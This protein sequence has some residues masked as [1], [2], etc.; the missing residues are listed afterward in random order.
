MRGLGTFILGFFLA[1]PL[2]GQTPTQVKTFFGAGRARYDIPLSPTLPGQAIVMYFYFATNEWQTGPICVGNP[3]CDWR[4]FD[5]QGNQFAQ[6]N[7]DDEKLLYIPSTKGGAETITLVSLAP[8]N[9]SF[10]AMIFPDTLIVQ[11]VSPA[12][13]NQPLL[14]F[15]YVSSGSTVATDDS[16]VISSY[17]LL[18]SVPHELFIGIGQCGTQCH[19]GLANLV[20]T[21]AAGWSAPVWG[22]EIFMSHATVPAKD[23][24]Q[25]FT[26]F[27]SPPLGESNYAYLGIQGFKAIPIQ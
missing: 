7:R 17:P 2:V 22:G 9:L 18:S 3:F 1:V 25:T 19:A 20:F 21:P 14:C 12:Y 10:V 16:T 8:G 24:R 4:I 23:T 5:S 27:P 15:P 13:C 11:D 6:V 26:L